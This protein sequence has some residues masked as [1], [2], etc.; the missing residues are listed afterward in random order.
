M[1]TGYRQTR[2]LRRVSW[3]PAV[4]G[5][6]PECRLP[7]LEDEAPTEPVLPFVELPRPLQNRASW[8]REVR[9]LSRQAYDPYR[10]YRTPKQAD[11]ARRLTLRRK[12]RRSA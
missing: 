5:R 8:V 9:G 6:L 1:L 10:L 4:A 11:S 3:E 7:H 2:F 12:F